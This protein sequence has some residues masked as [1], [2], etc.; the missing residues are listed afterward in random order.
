[1]ISFP[2]RYSCHFRPTVML[3]LMLITT[4]TAIRCATS[5]VPPCSAAAA[6]GTNSKSSSSPPAALSGDDDDF[7]ADGCR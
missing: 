7:G 5:Y 4:F 6:A 1:M 2:H 3:P